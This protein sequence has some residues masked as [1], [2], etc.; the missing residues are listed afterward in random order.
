M[1]KIGFIQ[2]LFSIL[3]SRFRIF[4][5]ELDPEAASNATVEFLSV[6][7][8]LKKRLPSFSVDSD[9]LIDLLRLARNTIHNNGVYFHPNMKDRRIT[10]KGEAYDFLA[11]QPITFVNWEWLLDRLEDTYYLMKAIVNAPQLISIQH[12]VV[13]PFSQDRP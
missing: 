2:N 7:Q 8:A 10:Y 12:K 1:I 9:T 3:D 11:G 6:Y 13:D 5:R 4:L